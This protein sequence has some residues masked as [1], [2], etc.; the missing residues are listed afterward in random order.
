M[1]LADRLL[2]LKVQDINA[3]SRLTYHISAPTGV[4]ISKIDRQSY[5]AGIGVRQGDVIRQIDQ[6]TI[7]DSKD[8]Q[9]AII[10]YRSKKSMVILV[11]RGER[12]Y[13]ITIKL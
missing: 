6:I 9:R 2:G 13:Y 8:F 4:Y 11:Q 3:R 12:G 1:D 7:N 10:K 5:L